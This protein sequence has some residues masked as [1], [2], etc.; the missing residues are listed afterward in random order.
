MS[1]VCE[2]S[3]RGAGGRASERQAERE[4]W[5]YARDV[6]VQKQPMAMQGKPRATSSSSRWMCE[7]RVCEWDCMRACGGLHCARQ[8]QS[9]LPGRREEHG[10]RQ[11]LLLS[12]EAL[13]KLSK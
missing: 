10:Q 9:D 11:R 7:R 13:P 1:E 12:V 3:K 2:A 5:I 4:E 6:R 8:R